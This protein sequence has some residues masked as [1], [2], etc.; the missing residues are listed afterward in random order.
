MLP[1]S[2]KTQFFWVWK[3][4]NS[5]SLQELYQIIEARER[6]FVVEQKLSYVDCDHFD[7]KALH[8]M[9]IQDGKIVAYLRAFP[10]GVKGKEASF[11]RVLV[12]KD[13]RGYG[14]GKD[15]TS[16]GLN[17]IKETFGDVPVRISAQAYLEKFYSG[18]G[19]K[20]VSDVYLEENIPHLKMI[21]N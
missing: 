4:F 13:A 7:Q 19:F 14:M 15:L 16:N 11:G 18:F 1:Y 8:L 12:L 2:K 5:L 17:K 10:P 9:G 6:V 21:R 3:E 20:T